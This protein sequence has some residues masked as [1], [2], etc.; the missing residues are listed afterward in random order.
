[1]LYQKLWYQS[2]AFFDGSQWVYKY[3]VEKSW[4]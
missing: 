4:V 3:F 1:M 2:T